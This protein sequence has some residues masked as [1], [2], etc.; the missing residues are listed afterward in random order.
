MNRPTRFQHAVFPGGNQIN[1]TS[2]PIPSPVDGEVILRVRRT[3][4][5]GSDNRLW[6][7][8]AE[9]IPGHEIFGVVEQPGHSRDG[10]RACVY[11]PVYCGHCDACSRGLTQSC[12]TQSVLIGWNR[13]GGFGEYVQVPEQ[14][15]LPV[16]D[17]I[18]D[19]LAP[20][21]LDTIGTSA[22]A[23]RTVTRWLEN[24]DNKRI[25]ITGAGPI[26]MGVLIALQ[27]L[28]CNEVRVFDPIA[29][30][31]TFAGELGARQTDN[32]STRRFDIIFECSG[33]HAARDAA[34]TQVA[35]GGAIVIIGE[36][37]APWEIKEG[38][39]FRRKDFAL[40]RSF[41]FPVCEHQDNIALLLR[42]K[43]SY[44][45]I[46]DVDLSLSELADGYQRFVAGDT[47]KP[48]LTIPG[49]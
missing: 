4:L 47:M 17:T 31:T 20:L 27:D 39:V 43:E 45:K 24:I 3:A 28:G 21:L 23:V 34:I 13:N 40:L 15:L 46:A 22:H 11:I 29:T 9:Q 25:L 35:P 42:Q 38:P 19:R 37:S 26:G 48:L 36:N 5:C 33:A 12:E 49:A 41:Y 7:D 44:E 10:E 6:R 30:R 2:S 16:P 14:C 8:G 18:T 32:D 1:I